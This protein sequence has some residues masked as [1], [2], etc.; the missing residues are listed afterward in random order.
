MYKEIKEVLEMKGTVLEMTEEVYSRL[1][2]L[3]KENKK[4]DVSFEKEL[5]QN[6]AA[7]I[8]DKNNADGR[9]DCLKILTA[10]YLA[11]GIG[12]DSC[13]APVNNLTES[14]LLNLRKETE[15]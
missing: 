4:I 11:V 9:E 3:S 12:M 5:V 2:V 13:G 7:A 15:V 8:S 1:C 10:Y 14:G 6:A